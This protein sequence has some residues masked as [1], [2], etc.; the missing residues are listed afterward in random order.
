MGKNTF[1]SSYLRWASSQSIH[2]RTKERQ[3]IKIRNFT[4]ANKNQSLQKLKAGE[5]NAYY[6]G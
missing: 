4:K 6:K 3:S 5:E 2:G 1:N